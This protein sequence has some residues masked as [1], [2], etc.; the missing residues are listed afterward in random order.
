MYSCVHGKSFAVFLLSSLWLNCVLLQLHSSSYTT[1][2]FICRPTNLA[3]YKWMHLEYIKDFEYNY[4]TLQSK[5]KSDAPFVM[6]ICSGIVIWR[7]SSESIGGPFHKR[8]FRRNSNSIEISFNSPFDFK[9]LIQWSL[10]TFVPGTTAVLSCMC[11]NAWRSDG[12]Q[13]N[14]DKAKFPSNLNFVSDLKI[15][16]ETGP[17]PP[18]FYPKGSVNHMAMVRSNSYGIRV[19]KML[20]FFSNCIKWNSL[21]INVGP[22]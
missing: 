15:V 6:F 5:P 9:I 11:K 14:H 10:Q 7:L 17:R 12:G 20:F 1:W 22:N 21:I 8:F 16:S 3:E 19:L 4:D 13:R 2:M 18:I